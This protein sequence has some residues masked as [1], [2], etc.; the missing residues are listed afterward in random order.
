MVDE[1]LSGS[2]KP[3]TKEIGEALNFGTGAV[4]AGFDFFVL[5]VSGSLRAAIGP[6]FGFYIVTI[7]GFY[8][9]AHAHFAGFLGFVRAFIVL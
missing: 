5:S 8:F 9:A 6:V 4:L 1:G 2:R 7:F 3:A